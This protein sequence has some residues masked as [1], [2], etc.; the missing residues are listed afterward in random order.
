[1]RTLAMTRKPW[2]I[3]VTCVLMGAVTSGCPRRTAPLDDGTLDRAGRSGGLDE[4]SL[5][6]SSLDRAKQGLPPEEDGVLRDVHFS[7][8]AYAVDGAAQGVLEA[9]TAWLRSNASAKV[10]LEGHCDDRGTIEY[11]LALGARR[12]KVVKDYLLTNGVTAD[13]IATISYGEE[14]PVCHEQDDGCW[15]RNRRVHFVILGQ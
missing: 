12:A 7:Y 6:G 5:G 9:N 8:D 1:M 4:R 15:A 3:L 13:R 14:L 11:N 10:E 2:L